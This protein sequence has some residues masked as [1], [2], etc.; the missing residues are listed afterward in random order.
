MR[1]FL[2]L[3]VLA[4]LTL[5]ACS[6]DGDKE[7]V[8]EESADV[9]Y[10]KAAAALDEKNYREATKYFE[11]VERQHPYSE[12]AT[13]S[14]LMAAYSSYEGQ[15]YDEAVIALDRFIE[16]HPG[17]KD[18]DYAYYLRALCFYEQISDVRRDQEMT[19]M[20]LESLE[21]LIRLFPDSRYSRDAN[22]KR[23]LTLDHLAG[24]EMEIGRY[25]LNRGQVTAAVNR[26]RTVIKDYQTTTHT[27]EALHRLVECYLSLGLKQ[28]ALHVAAVLGYNYPGDKWYTR[29]YDL[30]DP[31]SR[32]RLLNERDFVDRTI[33]SI[34]KPD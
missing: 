8:A 24:K 27:P 15:D 25:Y 21:A 14:Q 20:S 11:E 30:L 18:I 5:A 16:L 10:N 4:L 12:W 13:Q 32:E 29:T 19:Q 34:F 26:F 31:S 28:E 6:G 7:T 17:H 3:P 33:D 2:L 9:L 22:L 23:D 1:F